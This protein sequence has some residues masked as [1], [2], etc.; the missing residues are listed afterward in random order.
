M[1]SAQSTSRPTFPLLFMWSDGETDLYESEEEA[2]LDLEWF[3]S[4][5][6]RSARDGVSIVDSQ[7]RKVRLLV[8]KFEM[9]YCELK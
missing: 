8:E 5:V 3:D 2:A 1:I 7:G 6:P 4:E 9:I